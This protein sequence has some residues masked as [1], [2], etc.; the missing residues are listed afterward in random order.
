MTQ[1]GRAFS[2]ERGGLGEEATSTDGAEEAAE[3]GGVVAVM[4][5]E[6]VVEL[7]LFAVLFP[8]SPFAM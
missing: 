7:V 6:E 1:S 3:E 5:D 2:S 8:L 4:L